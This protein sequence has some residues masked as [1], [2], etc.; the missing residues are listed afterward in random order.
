MTTEDDR[1]SN[2]SE[3]DVWRMDVEKLKVKSFPV[4]ETEYRVILEKKAYDEIQAHGQ[5]D[6]DVEVCGVLMGQIFRD[7]TGP[8]LMVTDAIRGKQARQKAGQVTFTH[9]TWEY[10]HQETEKQRYADK[11]IVGWY[12]MH[13]GLGVFL[14]EVDLFAH[15]NFFNAAWQVAIVIDQKVKKTGI[16]FWQNGKV[17]RL[18]RYWIGDEPCW[19]TSENITASTSSRQA[20]E[21]IKYGFFHSG[22][23]SSDQDAYQSD[24]FLIKLLTVGVLVILVCTL[25]YQTTVIRREQRRLRLEVETLAEQILSRRY[26]N[27]RLLAG[28]PIDNQQERLSQDARHEDLTEL[29]E[30]ILRFD[31]AGIKSRENEGISPVFTATPESKK[32]NQ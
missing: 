11:R 25:A 19:D 22:R 21:K 14:S 24:S 32:E 31:S 12:H 27:A 30:K 2:P 5:S 8:Y 13:P 28:L 10:I 15:R 29:I 16:F 7:E 23:Q 1:A 18:K 4:R 9:S 17:V 3:P 6:L 26:E 20:D